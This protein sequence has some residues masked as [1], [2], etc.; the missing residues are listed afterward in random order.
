MQRDQRDSDLQRELQAHLDLETEDRQATGL[1]PKQARQ[2]AHR[3]LGN[4]TALRETVYE[5][6]AFSTADRWLKDLRY[7]VR[8]L[9][10]SAAFATVSILSLALGIG[11]ATAIFTVADQ[12]LLRLLP[13]DR[14]N[15]LRLV[16]WDGSFIGGSSR[17]WKSAFSY[18][19]F[20]ELEEQTPAALAGLAARYQ[21]EASVEIASQTDRANVELVSGGYF[22]VLG[23]RP[24][25]G[26]L[27]SSQDDDE[28]DGEPWV[29][30]TH[31]YWESRF[32]ADP[33]I[34]GQ[35]VRINGFPFTVIGVSQP[36]LKG[37]ETL[38]PSDLFVPLQ[39]K[40]AITPTWD[41]RDRR[42]SI[43]L[44]VLARLSPGASGS[45]AEAALMHPYA[46]V[47]RRDL[48]AHARPEERQQRY[49]RNTLSLEEGAQG[50]GNARSLVAKPLQILLGMV[51]LLLLI[52]CVNLATLFVI[53]STKR[54][55]EIAVRS[56]LGASRAAMV[57][58]V[59]I[60][61]LLIAGL[62]AGL[63]LLFA[64]AGVAALARLV[65]ADRLGI[66]FETS[67]DLRVLTFAVATAAVAALSFGLAPAIQSTRRTTGAALKNEAAS[68]SASRSQTRVRRTL[69]AAQIALSLVLLAAAGLFGKSMSQLF[70]TPSGLAVET[71]LAF[72]VNPSE[73]G[74][75][76]ARA[77]RFALDL[78]RRLQLEP[79]VESVSVA[80]DPLL[81]GVSGGNTVKVEGYRPAEG[82]DMQAGANYVLP[83]FFSTVGIGLLAGREFTE[84]D[85]D[86][87]P[88]VTI[89]NETFANRFLGSAANAVGR[90][91]GTFGSK[92]P[93]PFE[94]VGVV[95][96]HKSVNL[97]EKPSPRTY[98]PLLQLSNPSVITV[99]L[100]A[101]AEPE[102][103]ASAAHRAVQELDPELSAYGVKTLS[104]Q[105]T[106]THYVE[107]LFARL[108]AA[109]AALATL[110]AALGLYGVAAFSV[111]RRTREIGV[112]VALGAERRA[113]FRMVLDEALMLALAGIAV[114]V[115]LAWGLGKAV[116]AQL[117]GVAAF[118]PTVTFLGIAVVTTAAA[119]AGL[120]PARRATRISPV[121]ALRHE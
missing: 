10:R 4:A 97:R 110:L 71:L 67:P 61:C 113:I 41:H 30:L 53:R 87:A 75:D 35:T 22:D 20:R 52:T 13:V 33:S 82:E 47:L 27:L 100:R 29:V 101:Q 70:D 32:A 44:N 51:A 60:E 121:T 81:A 23:V 117:Y 93:F 17:G 88:R 5:M 42:D 72:F 62:G 49:L 28:R 26:R 59:M 65:P 38:R 34:L 1:P 108:S 55:R 50:R 39:M 95:E 54:G 94:I 31:A 98:M 112:R 12:A 99:Y 25:L 120:L 19:A 57:R 3:D 119:L 68:I 85:A 86:G 77:R 105:L 109:F 107:R 76:G 69:V 90:R 14:P 7:A 103:L 73:H 84:R 91:V 21:T 96:D 64:R 58:L 11:A 63:G 115:P 46:G 40:A 15:E 83:G 116:E 106:E 118:D 16:S 6:S 2:A 43:W 114:G 8:S 48:Q 79:G 24:A 111:A 36:G 92:P 104:S 74:Y 9:I 80:T 78:Q 102:T 45:E 37:L 18:P 66:V 89:V 56:S